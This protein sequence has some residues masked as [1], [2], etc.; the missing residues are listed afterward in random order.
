MLITTSIYYSWIP[1]L[2]FTRLIPLY[3]D[4]ART[5]D[6]QIHPTRAVQPH[7]LYTNTLDHCPYASGLIE[8]FSGD[9]RQ[10]AH[11]YVFAFKNS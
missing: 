9:L 11:H 5:V 1:S 6:P 10:I 7:L 3:P 2:S 4:L 8:P